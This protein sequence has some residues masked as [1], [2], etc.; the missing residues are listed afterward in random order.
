MLQQYLILNIKKGS[1]R[2]GKRI[3]MIKVVEVFWDAAHVNWKM[4]SSFKRIY[5]L[6]F[7]AELEIKI[8][9]R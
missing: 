6:R 2:G 1:G 7:E 4:K 3:S 9:T 8:V 5:K